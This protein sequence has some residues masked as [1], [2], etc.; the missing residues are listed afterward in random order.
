MNAGPTSESAGPGVRR[1]RS[2]P[3]LSFTQVPFERCCKCDRQHRPSTFSKVSPFLRHLVASRTQPRSGPEFV[4]IAVDLPPES[5][6]G[7]GLK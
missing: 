1:T 7:C 6:T 4:P 3:A 5:R 2:E